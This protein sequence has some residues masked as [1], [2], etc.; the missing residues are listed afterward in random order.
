MQSIDLET[1]QAEELLET[2]RARFEG[3]MHR[4]QNLRWEEVRSRLE[5]H[6]EGLWSLGEMDRTGGEPD[7]VGRAGESRFI[8][9]DCSPES[10]KGR[11]SVCYD[12]EALAARK[13]HKPRDSAVAMASAMGAALLDEKRYRE[14][15]ALGPC[16]TKTSSW[17]ATPP[18]VRELGGAIFGDFRYG[19]VFVYHNG[20]ESYYAARGFRCMLEV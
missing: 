11:R 20:A 9:V 19:R 3:N 15:Q 16:D 17:L 10:P 5:A 8:F 6:P 4:H 18:A 12:A 1:D 13:K 2:L 7:V 14:L